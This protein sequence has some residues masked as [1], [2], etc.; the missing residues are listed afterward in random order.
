MCQAGQEIDYSWPNL[1]VVDPFLQVEFS[2][3]KMEL[4]INP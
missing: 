1:Q 3:G 2:I 4:V